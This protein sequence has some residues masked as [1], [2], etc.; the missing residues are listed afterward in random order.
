M[1]Y[2]NANQIV[3]E[4]GTQLSDPVIRQEVQEFANQCYSKA[5]FKLKSTNSR[6]SDA[7]I[8][9]VGWIGSSYSLSCLR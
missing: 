8:N 5:Y 2:G 4:M 7:T 9:S 3:R 6:L 1:P